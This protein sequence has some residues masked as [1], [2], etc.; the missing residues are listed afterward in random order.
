MLALGIFGGR[1]LL[2]DE[3]T[4][5]ERWAV[6]AHAGAIGAVMLPTQVAMSP[7][8]RFVASVGGEENWMLLDAAHGAERMAGAKHDGTGACV[9]Q[10][11]ERGHRVLQ[12]ECPEVA[13]IAGQRALAFSPCGQR[14]AT[15]DVDGVVIL[16]DAE[17]ERA[18]Q[19]MQAG[20]EMVW[21]LSFTADGARL[22][23]ASGD[24]EIHVWDATTGA[25]LRTWDGEDTV[26][27]VQF[28]PVNSSIVAT[29]SLGEVTLWDVDSGETLNTF[30]GCEFGFAV[31]SPDGRT[32]A[33]AS[34]ANDLLLVDAATGTVRLTLVGHQGLLSAACFSVDDGSK[35]ASASE[36]GTCKV[37]DSSTG[38]LLRTIIVGD[39]IRGPNA[40]SW[41]RD[42]VRDTQRGVAFAMGHHPRLGEGSRVLALDAGVVR[43]ILDRV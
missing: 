33:T 24:G 21:Y 9:C 4:G 39:L 31:F 13:H 22:A 12:A 16:W 27:W 26:T 17:T 37:W 3:A 32:I 34:D 43:M 18:E 11:D 10:V 29:V 40:V 41:G 25:L 42:W 6:Q 2:V 28:S 5:E 19:R 7:S 1:V 38:A 23:C 8:G 15:G 30:M 35:L 14:F 20:P 36:D